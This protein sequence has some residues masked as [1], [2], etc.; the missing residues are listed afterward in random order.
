MIDKINIG[1]PQLPHRANVE[2][3]GVAAAGEVED[4]D[5]RERT[6]QAPQRRDSV[7]LSAAARALSTTEVQNTSETQDVQ[8][9]PGR[10]NTIV[11]RLESG[12][13]DSDGALG[14]IAHGVLRDLNA[15]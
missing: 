15:E 2:S 4:S 9:S 11:N 3:K 5:S 8:L 7:E 6:Q 14:K 1:V 10:I 13:Y 12:F